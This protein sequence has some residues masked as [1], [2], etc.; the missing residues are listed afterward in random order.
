HHRAAHGAAD[1]RRRSPSRASGGCAL[2]R[3]VSRRLRS[4]RADRVRSGRDA[5]RRG[6]RASWRTILLMAAFPAVPTPRRMALVACALALLGAAKAVPCGREGGTTGVRRTAGVRGPT[7]VGPRFSGAVFDVGPQPGVQAR[8][9]VS[10]IPA[11]TEM[12][13]AM[14]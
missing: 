5:G 9:I 2:R 4:R 12:L 10:I 8:R 1:R 3:I 7:G 11:T 13:F 6:D 14:G